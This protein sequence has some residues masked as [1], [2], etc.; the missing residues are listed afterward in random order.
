MSTTEMKEMIG[1]HLPPIHLLG[2]GNY[3]HLF[4]F[5]SICDTERLFNSQD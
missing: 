1:V 3:R 2:E 4:F 5:M